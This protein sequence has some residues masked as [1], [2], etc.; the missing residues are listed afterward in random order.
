VIAFLSAKGGVGTSSL[1]AN[2]G[3]AI[4]RTQ[5]DTRVV[6]VDLVLPIG[7]IAPIVGYEGHETLISVTAMDESKITPDYF[8]NA[9]SPVKMWNFSLL[10]GSSNPEQANALQAG[11]IEKVIK[12]LANTFD[13]VLVDMGRALSR[14]SLPIIQEAMAIAL[15]TGTDVS[16]VS[17]TKTVY[18][19]LRTQNV[20]PK[21]IY[22]I[23]NRAVGLEGLTKSEAETMIGFPIQATI[24]YMGGNFALAN[25]RHEPILVKFPTDTASMMIQQV[26]TQLP[27]LAQRIR[28]Q[29]G[30]LQMK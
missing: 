18:D 10:A 19:Y 6:V 26:A 4:S 14:I 28:V 24:P 16:A 8:L 23:L 5:A 21:R 29:T 9:M 30:Q 12:V 15:V 25:N 1:C 2:I 13:Y 7:S 27:Q 11:K 22:G 17:L 3:N 20:D